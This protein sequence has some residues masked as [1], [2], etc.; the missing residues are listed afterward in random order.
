[1]K[2][3]ASIKMGGG[4]RLGF[5]LVELLVVIAI[6]GILIGLLLPAVQAAREAARRMECTNKLK[7]LALGCHV[8]VDAKNYF[9][10]AVNQKDFYQ[11]GGYSSYLLPLLPFIE[12]N[13]LYDTIYTMY[14]TGMVEG[15]Y[16]G[17]LDTGDTSAY[18]PYI[19][20]VSAFVCPSD[21]NNVKKDLTIKGTSYRCCRGDII[22]DDWYNESR[23]VFTNGAIETV[24]FGGI[25]DGTSNTMMLSEMVIEPEVRGGT[26][27]TE[28]VSLITVDDPFSKTKP[29]TCMNERGPNGMVRHMIANPSWP[30]WKRG[31]RWGDSRHI[32]T[33]FL[34]VLPPNAPSCSGTSY[35]NSTVIPTASSNH[36]GGVN[37]AMADGSVRFVSDTINTKNLDMNPYDYQVS[38]GRSYGAVESEPQHY[39]GPAFY[40]VWAELATRSGSETPSL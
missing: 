23:G 6:I 10:N 29:I 26:K 12:Q 4:G 36:S 3:F 22:V 13:A 24:N 5:T 30:G 39:S 31:G 38:V 17:N 25:K 2:K 28:A 7:Q 8:M 9:P 27:I 33:Q 20:T 14:T 21:N 11:Y 35:K 40:G 15:V 34:A 37:A 18:S 1:M 19:V 32:H 16:R